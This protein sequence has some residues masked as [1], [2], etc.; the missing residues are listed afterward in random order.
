MD[1]EL[2]TA[3]LEAQQNAYAPYS[4]F[5]VGAALLTADGQIITGCNV[6]NASYPLA[7]C[8]ER[9]AVYRAVAQGHRQFV[10]ILVVGPGPALISP[11]GGCRQVLAEFGDLDVVMAERTGTQ[12]P[13][14]VPLHDLLPMAFDRKDLSHGV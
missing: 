14:V 1:E 3:A 4:G 2:L 9:N 12:E 13:K 10:R 7:C 5:A 6:E 11:C 8:A